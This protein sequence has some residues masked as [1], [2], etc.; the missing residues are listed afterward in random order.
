MAPYLPE[1]QQQQQQQQHEEASPEWQPAKSAMAWDEHGQQQQW[2]PEA[3]PTPPLSPTAAPTP[4]AAAMAP[5]EPMQ[6]DACEEAE[7]PG[8]EVEQPVPAAPQQPAVAE[9]AMPAADMP[10]HPE[11]GTFAQ[12]TYSW[13][14]TAGEVCVTVQLPPGTRGAACGVDITPSHL[15]AGLRAQPP[16]IDGQL[17]G[18]VDASDSTWSVVDGSALEVTLAKADT[19]WWPALLE[20][21]PPA[22]ASH[23]AQAA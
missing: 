14:Q 8:E 21:A 13:S 16:A 9:V 7:E 1:L 5:E 6:L 20:A 2:R 22:T 18:C 10:A 11:G 12:P 17:W 4:A 3:P 23:G 15:R 19:S